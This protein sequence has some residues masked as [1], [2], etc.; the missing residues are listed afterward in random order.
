MG[1]SNERTALEHA[2][3]EGQPFV[4]W[5]ESIVIP[6]SS[7][8]SPET[9]QIHVRALIRP[10]DQNRSSP[11]TGS[12]VR[13]GLGVV[14]TLAVLIAPGACD[15]AYADVTV[16]FSD[17][18]AQNSGLESAEDLQKVI[19]AGLKKIADKGHQ[20]AKDLLNSNQTIKIIC[21]TEE[22]AKRFPEFAGGGSGELGDPARTV[23][24][25]DETGKPKSR[26]T[27]T[28]AVD[29]N[30]LNAQGW[31]GREIKTVYGGKSQGLWEPLVH[32]LL[33]AT[34][35][36]RKHPPDD[37]SLY[38]QWV[39]D[40]N[41][42]IAPNLAQLTETVQRRQALKAEIEG[43][44]QR[45]AKAAPESDRQKRLQQ[46]LEDK[47][48]E[49]NQIEP[50]GTSTPPASSFP[51]PGH[52]QKGGPARTVDEKDICPLPL[53]DAVPLGNTRMLRMDFRFGG[54]MTQIDPPQT[55]PQTKTFSGNFGR[56]P[57][58]VVPRHVDVMDASGRTIRLTVEP[59][60]NFQ[61]Q[62][63]NDFVPVKQTLHVTGNDGKPYIANYELLDGQFRPAGKFQPA[64]ES[65]TAPQDGSTGRTSGQ[66]PRRF[67]SAQG[68]EETAGQGTRLVAAG[69]SGY[70][71]LGSLTTQASGQTSIKGHSKLVATGDI[72]KQT[73]SKLS[74]EPLAHLEEEPSTTE[75]F[76]DYVGFSVRNWS[77]GKPNLSLA[78]EWSASDEKPSYITTIGTNGEFE[79]KDWGV[80]AKTCYKLNVSYGYDRV[81]TA[82]SPQTARTYEVTFNA[83]P[84]WIA[85]FKPGIDINR[86]Q[87]DYMT[88]GQV[89]GTQY[90]WTHWHTPFPDVPMISSGQISDV[91]YNHLSWESP[92]KNFM[93]YGELNP[94]TNPL[95][96]PGLTPTD[97]PNSAADPLPVLVLT[98]TWIKE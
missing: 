35:R 53:E 58:G 56:F 98:G 91:G 82:I 52:E 20:G 4:E 71:A 95:P 97:W 60:G 94:G 40:F 81:S 33:H 46:Q 72:R 5:Q 39:V 49:L 19:N 62:L 76:D 90:T 25:F 16:R 93:V 42:A 36:D 96:V 13:R 32:E 87:S 70:A 11:A 26:G 63:P 44:Q 15:L 79:F 51:Q 29:C 17:T 45:L 66:E 22:E 47:R 86:F 88:A 14:S 10:S 3:T 59:D 64:P 74:L 34:H 89:G 43:I 55:N 23:G 41:Q 84:S 68:Q 54:G 92:H 27:T 8:I 38:E 1:Q 2:R 77:W 67:S 28:I 12:R 50:Q 24:D 7:L 48:R 18:V 30:V 37:T 85:A 75:Y 57:E 73:E 80:S 6:N 31:F 69:Q 83:N 65:S 9:L 78:P 21:Y 61:G